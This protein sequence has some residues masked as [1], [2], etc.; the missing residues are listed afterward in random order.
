MF[1]SFFFYI[2]AYMEERTYISKKE[3]R[4]LFVKFLMEN[5]CLKQYIVCFKDFNQNHKNKTASE[6]ID[7]TMDRLVGQRINILGQIFNK[8]RVS[9]EWPSVCKPMREVF[10]ITDFMDA[11]NFWS[12]LSTKLEGLYNNTFIADDGC[13]N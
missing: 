8:I 3:A 2:F 7:I 6:V 11:I 5:N 10:G 12:K 4:A 1:T 9:F 13:N